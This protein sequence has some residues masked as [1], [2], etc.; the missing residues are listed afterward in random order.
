MFAEVLHLLQANAVVRKCL[1]TL[2]IGVMFKQL[3]PGKPTRLQIWTD[4]AKGENTKGF[5]VLGFLVLWTPVNEHSLDG[6]GLLVESSGKQATRKGKSSLHVEA[7]AGNA[8]LERGQKNALMLAE[9]YRGP[10]HKEE[11]LAELEAGVLLFPLELIVERSAS[12]TS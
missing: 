10:R 8:G 7:L 9:G 11:V 2:H 3:P 5:P 4:G 6:P 1:D 12:T